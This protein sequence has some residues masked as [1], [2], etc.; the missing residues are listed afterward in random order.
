[1]AAPRYI[2]P[3]DTGLP[4]ITRDDPRRPFKTYELR[5][6]RQVFVDQLGE[7]WEMASRR[8]HADALVEPPASGLPMTRL[9]NVLARR[10]AP[11]D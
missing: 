9:R 1:M 4:I 5:G 10:S 2:P 8:Q 7:L 11:T 3:D 6:G